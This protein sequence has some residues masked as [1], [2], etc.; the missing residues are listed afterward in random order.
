[1]ARSFLPGRT[2]RILVL[3]GVAVVIAG[4]YF[5]QDFLIPLALSLLLSFLLAPL[6]QRLERWKLG[7]VGSVII[8]VVLGL[9]LL[10]GIGGIVTSQLI[11]LANKLPDYKN[12]IHAKVDRWRS[13]AGSF[14]Q[15]TQVLQ[16]SLKDLTAPKPTSGPTTRDLTAVAQNQPM[17][18]PVAK[19]V[20]NLSGTPT[21]QPIQ[22][23]IKER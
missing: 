23:E 11:D 13:R 19:A 20:Q 8:V 14:S 7:R 18:P 16:D 4:L 17:S 15:R 2:P 21:T 12:N 5:A 22:V 10:V 6:C 9:G 1:M 3:A